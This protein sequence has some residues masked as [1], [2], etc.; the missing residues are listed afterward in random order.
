[1]PNLKAVSLLLKKFF[2]LLMLCVL[3]LST[4]CAKNEQ[5]ERKEGEYQKIKLVMTCNGTNIATNSKTCRKFADLVSA[6]SGGNITIDVFANDQLAGG[7]MSK[8]VEMI[9]DGAVDLAAYA[10]ASLPCLTKNFLSAL[11]LG[12]STIIKR[13]AAL[14]TTRAANIMQ[15]VW[16]T[17]A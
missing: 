8:G 13:R 2:A 5:G 11:C 7:N 12:R 3:I 16:A 17:K 10:S 4:G 15:V 6:A 14:S 9:A 1:M